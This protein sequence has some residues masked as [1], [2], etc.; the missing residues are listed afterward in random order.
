VSVVLELDR[1]PTRFHADA[2]DRVI[3]AMARVNG[4]RLA[5]RDRRLRRASV[6]PIWNP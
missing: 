1:L 4:L 2:A 5:T 6:V 3:V